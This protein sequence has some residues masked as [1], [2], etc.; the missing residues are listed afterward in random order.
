MA[1]AN[2]HIASLDRIFD[3]GEERNGF[4]R[5]DRNERTIP[6]SKK[7]TSKILLSITP[8]DLVRYPCQKNMYS[9]M[10]DFY[11]VDVKSILLS[12]G[13]DAAIKYIF[14]TFIQDGDEILMLSPTYAMPEV[15]AKM[16]GAI[17]VKVDFGQNLEMSAECVLAKK[18]EKTKIIYI[19]NPNQPTGTVFCYK[20]LIKLAE[21]AE[22]ED[23]IL[24]L[25][26]A[27]IE[28]SEEPSFL[29]NINRFHNVIV[30]RTFSK[31]FGLAPA[32]MGCIIASTAMLK[33]IY[34]LKPL[35]D[36]N[37]LAIKSSEY[38]IKHYSIVDKYIKEIQRSKLYLSKE[39]K[40]NGLNVILSHT[41]FVHIQIPDSLDIV[42][43]V[44]HL[45]DHYILVRSQGNGLPATISGCIRITVG[46]KKQMRQFIGCLK[47]FLE[48]K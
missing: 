1:N 41:N 46:T 5:L 38:L 4:L 9:L 28:F 39:L 22:R 17:S 47:L 45:R 33:Q 26:E 40:K 30:L 34:K 18:T 31:A 48:N 13:S 43:L 20:D 3:V 12:P 44:N 37:I 16:F 25:D 27:Y 29:K 35:H 11:G 24:L 10:S 6:F 8:E 15:Y 7:I 32:R 36:I 23:F 19:A 14:E 21:L 42:G 2:K